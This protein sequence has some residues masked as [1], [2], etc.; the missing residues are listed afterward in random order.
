MQNLMK[1]ATVYGCTFLAIALFAIVYFSMVKTIEISGVAQDDVQLA[2]GSEQETGDLVLQNMLSFDTTMVNTD[3]L[4]IPLDAQV[5]PDDITIENHYMD[6]ELYIFIDKTDKLFYRSHPL[7]GYKDNIL[8][9]SYEE[10]EKG[11]ALKFVMNGIYEY[12]TVLENNALY[13]TSYAPHELYD[14]IV[15]IDPARGGSDLGAASEGL[16]EKDIALSITKK[17][18]E[19]LDADGTVKVYYTRM[20]DVNPK[21]ELRV[22]LPNKI[23]ADAYIRIEVDNVNDNSVYGVTALYN[24]EYFI[25]GFGNV[26]IADIMESSVVTAVKGKALG[27]YKS[28]ENDYTLLHS[29]VPSTTI[30]VGCISNKQEAILLGRNDYIEKIAQGIFNGILKMY[31][32]E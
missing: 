15:V 12:K 32:S 1:K 23:R 26:E 11:L 6:S 29:T 14:K 25:P 7:S 9:G 20:D 2:Q 4:T 5:M 13:V 17:L 10:T 21:E 16:Y 18:K 31:E 27:I 19:M 8:E 30:K 3:Y 22:N 24:D 28:K